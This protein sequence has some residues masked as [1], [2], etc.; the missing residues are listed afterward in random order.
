MKKRIE[1]IAKKFLETVHDK[2]ALAQFSS[3]VIKYVRSLS[4]N[5]NIIDEIKRK[6]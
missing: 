1:Q 2:E 5:T 3:D 4:T 6:R